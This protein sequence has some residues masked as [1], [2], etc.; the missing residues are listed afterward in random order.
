MEYAETGNLTGGANDNSDY[1]KDKVQISADL[2]KPE[3][4]I[5][6]DA[7]T[8]GGLLIALPPEA[9]DKF[10]VEALSIG[11]TA[12]EIGEVLEKDKFEIIVY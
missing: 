4:D 10:L 1:L 5:L 12:A 3:L 2:K 11:L 8:S 9:G 7:Q 6:Y